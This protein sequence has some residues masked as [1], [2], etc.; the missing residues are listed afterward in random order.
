MH[1]GIFH[2]LDFLSDGRQLSYLSMPLSLDRSP[3]YQVRTPVCRIRNGSGPRIVLMAGNHGDEYE[4]EICLVRLMRLVRP[5]M[6]RG[7]LTIVPF[8]NYPAVMA[9]RRSSPFDGGNLNRTFPGNPAGT[10]TERIAAFLETELFSRADIV[11]DLH[12]GGTSMEHLP[13]ALIESN[14]NPSRHQRALDLMGRLGMPFGFVATNGNAAPT[15]MAAAAR[16]GAIGLSGEFGGC[17]TVSAQTMRFAAQAINRLLLITGMTD[18]PLLPAS[19]PAPEASMRLL[20][21][22]SHDQ[23]IYATRRGWFEPA[24]DLGQL[25]EAGQLAGYLHDFQRLDL[26]E[27]C[28][29]FAKGGVVISRRLPTDSQPGDCLMQV[30]RPVTSTSEEKDR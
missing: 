21:L 2:D 30:A 12:A 3:Y 11:F 1:T 26:A 23:A 9:A 16:A 22:D 28:L 10:P 17:G 27:E 6:I 8:A 7:E 20:S 29:Y 25:V 4:G 15:S 18:Q 19:P 24:C 5:E 13:C 14:E